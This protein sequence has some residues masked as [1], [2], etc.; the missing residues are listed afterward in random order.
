MVCFYVYT[1]SHAVRQAFWLLEDFLQHK[2]GITTLLYLSKIDINSLN[3]QFLFLTKNTDNLQFFTT[4]D[5]GNITIL[6]IN[7]LICIFYNRTSIRTQEELILANTYHQRTLLACSNYLVWIAL[8]EYSYGVSTNHL[9]E[10]H[11]DSCQQ[12]QLLVLLD[13]FYQLHQNLSI[14][15]RY[16]LHALSL[17]LRLQLSIVLNDTIVD[18]GQIM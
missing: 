15:I 2:V 14:R 13:I 17:Q 8:V 5:N 3:G 10:S 12:I 18:N 4:T 16:K 7:H 6:Q 9:I 11:L 1:T